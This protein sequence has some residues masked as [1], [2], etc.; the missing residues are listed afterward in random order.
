MAELEKKSEK[1]LIRE[2]E[3]KRG[4]LRDFRFSVAGSK[5]RNTH[6]GRHARKEIARRMTELNKR[7]ANIKV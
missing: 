6:E 4:E 3:E 2:I 5:T 1:D 7:K